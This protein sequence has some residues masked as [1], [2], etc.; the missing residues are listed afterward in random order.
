[1][2]KLNYQSKIDPD[3]YNVLERLFENKSTFKIKLNGK[4]IKETAPDWN[5]D[6]WRKS[7]SNG[8]RNWWTVDF[9]YNENEATNFAVVRA[10]HNNTNYYIYR[11]RSPV[12]KI[13]IVAP[14]KGKVSICSDKCSFDRDGDLKGVNL[15]DGLLA[16]KGESNE[17]NLQIYRYAYW[18]FFKHY[19][20]NG[21]IGDHEN[22]NLAWLYQKGDLTNLEGMSGFYYQ[23]RFIRSDRLGT[24]DWQFFVQKQNIQFSP[25]FYDQ[26]FLKG[27]QRIMSKTQL[28]EA[29]KTDQ[30]YNACKTIGDQ[31]FDSETLFEYC[32]N[33]KS[34]D[35]KL[36]S[37]VRDD[38]YCALPEYENDI[39]CANP[40]YC[41][42]DDNY[43]IKNSCIIKQSENH[44][45]AYCKN[46]EPY[47]AG[48]VR[49]KGVEGKTRTYQG[50]NGP[51]EVNV[52]DQI[53]KSCIMYWD[54]E[55]GDVT[56]ESNPSSF[57]NIKKESIIANYGEPTQEEINAYR[58]KC[59]SQDGTECYKYGYEEADSQAKKI[60]S[61]LIRHK[62]NDLCLLP[63]YASS[64]YNSKPCTS[65]ICIQASNI[66]T[67]GSL[68]TQ[69]RNLN[70]KQSCEQ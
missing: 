42:K 46:Y 58:N 12:D 50:P 24:L 15:A 7:G 4:F 1:M 53:I 14:E 19:W 63:E 2:R 37:G 41:E 48:R 20:N 32:K 34:E 40:S 49:V 11:V 57:Y 56:H 35:C 38:L 13:T 9:T 66:D 51:V 70:I 65:N 44:R 18:S 5:I 27:G 55:T 54:S 10:K 30:Y 17:E 67:S 6:G 52:E 59:E 8:N 31:V 21:N 3:N 60:A 16:I 64:P 25:I 69:I 23:N 29:C 28:V 26:V 22:D 62:I 47:F 45:A 61:S 36:L 68:S 33:N 43:I 39:K